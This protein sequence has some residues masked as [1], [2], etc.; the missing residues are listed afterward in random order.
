MRHTLFLVA[1]VLAAICA[2]Y[3]DASLVRSSEALTFDDDIHL[4]ERETG[5]RLRLQSRGTLADII[6]LDRI[7]SVKRVLCKDNKILVRLDDDKP[8]VT[9]TKGQIL[10]G[11]PQWNCSHNV[12]KPE[13]HTIYA[14]IGTL[15]R[16]K[17]RVVEIHTT[18]AGPLE[19]FDNAVIKVHYQQGQLIPSRHKRYLSNPLRTVLNR[20]DY[21]ASFTRNIPFNN[22]GDDEAHKTVNLYKRTGKYEPDVDTDSNA[23]YDGKDFLFRCHNCHGYSQISY[24]MELVIYKVDNKPIIKKYMLEMDVNTKIT[25]EYTITTDQEISLTKTGVLLVNH[26]TPIFEVPL[27][28]FQTFSP[29]MLTVN[30]STQANI[31]LKAVTKHATNY[32]GNVELRGR[33]VISQSFVEGKPTKNDV[34]VYNW[35]VTTTDQRVDANRTFNATFAFYQNMTITPYISWAQKDIDM[36]L[37]PPVQISTRPTINAVSTGDTVK[38]CNRVH[39]Y[40]DT[41]VTVAE[42]DF[43]VN[44]FGI[45]IWNVKVMDSLSR[46]IDVME[47]ELSYKCHADCHAENYTKNNDVSMNTACGYPSKKLT[48]ND[49]E[50]SSLYQ[51]WGNYVLF[52]A[53]ER[54]ATWCGNRGRACVDCRDHVV[55][56]TVNDAC[57]DR[58]VSTELAASVSRLAKFIEAEWPDRKLVIQEAFDEDTS[59]F[60]NGRHENESVFYEGRGAEMSITKA[61]AFSPAALETD[62]YVQRRLSE[63]AVCANFAYVAKEDAKVSAC[64]ERK[65]KSDRR[66]R[67][68]LSRTRRSG[69]VEHTMVKE[70]LEKLGDAVLKSPSVNLTSVL[71]LPVGGQYPQGSAMDVACGAFTGSVSQD[72]TERFRRLIEYPLSDVDFEPEGD[73]GAWCGV[74]TRRCHG[75]CTL[76]SGD[77]DDHWNWCGTRTMHMRLAARL[78]RLTKILPASERV[79][80]KKALTMNITNVKDKQFMEG[81]AAQITLKAGGSLSS[82]V[83]TQYAI[84]AGFD[85][86]MRVSND[87]INV[88]VKVQDG[89][90]TNLAQFPTANLISVPLPLG[91]EDEYDYPESLRNESRKPLLFD[92]STSSGDVSEHFKLNAFVS[93]GKRYIRL[94]TMLVYLLDLSYDDFKG[95][96]YGITGSGYRPRS[97]NL[98]NIATR[99]EKEQ[100]R[101]EMGQAVEL[102]PNDVASED[103]LFRLAISLIRIAKSVR[104]QQIGIGIGCKADRLYFDVRPIADENALVVEVWDSGN[105]PLFNRL[106]LIQDMIAQGGSVVTARPDPVICNTPALGRE[107]F[108]FNF[109]LDQEGHCWKTDNSF[110]VETHES[111]YNVSVILQ[112]RLTSAAGT[113]KLPRP[114]IMPEIEAC[115]VDT[116]GGCPSAGS[117]WKEKVVKCTKMI[118]RYLARASVPFQPLLDKVSIFNTD[119]HQSSVHSLACHDGRVCIENTQIYALLLPLTTATYKHENADEL[120]FGGADNPSPLLEIV[121]Q[122]LAW[123]AVGN[124]DVYL[125]SAKDV[126]S[127]RNTIQI[128]LMYN[129]N[130]SLVTFHIDSETDEDDVIITLQRKVEQWVSGVCPTWSRLVTTPYTMTK[131]PTDRKKRSIERSKDRNEMNMQMRNWEVEWMLKS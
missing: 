21:N 51:L 126:N 99:H 93:P 96:F 41:N 32:K 63:L 46:K 80:V 121:E 107:Y 86:V 19:V 20:V 84:L 103:N 101:F 36:K 67:S 30:A 128:L 78:Q 108:Y 106:K 6:D 60:P 22:M 9:W 97:V 40:V 58:I 4:E 105:T 13:S 75:D 50:F 123:R 85:Y 70:L 42:T 27:A 94:D 24:Y 73:T 111:R 8:D 25:H 74:E 5:G 92:V 2:A 11:G 90:Q 15:L 110:C 118:L 124:V 114:D 81:R 89:I 117:V 44:A 79:V 34:T 98:D 66:R 1:A 18:E 35:T 76:H 38:R 45:H 26:S 12:Y 31:A 28:T 43:S 82:Q 95:G 109:D 59:D 119:N 65:L 56:D 3:E 127:L 48:R 100:M 125:E 115:V 88:C 113:G 72:H 102:K 47:A 37:G 33:T 29:I 62:D 7:A 129:K 49:I 71:P 39:V 77:I 10:I 16:P 64:V 55:S 68:L 17:E 14:K 54:N 52:S 23:T 91:E 122:E 104:T 61:N 120:I 131:I 53:E 112:R 57:A 130:V 83:F 69:H 87:V 116:C